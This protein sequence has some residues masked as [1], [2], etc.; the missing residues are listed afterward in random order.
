[1]YVMVSKFWVWSRLKSRVVKEKYYTW[2]Y[3]KSIKGIQASIDSILE[4][5][6]GTQPIFIFA[7]G[8]SWNRQLFQR[9]QQLALALAK[10]GA[11]VFYLDPLDS[12]QAP[13]FTQIDHQLFRVTGPAKLIEQVPKPFVYLLPWS[14][15][16]QARF[17]SP[18]II[19]DIV[20][21]L[22]AFKVNRHF[23]Y[24]QHEKRLKVADLVLVTA[25]RLYD[26][27]YPMR[28]DVILCPNG[29][30]YEHFHITGKTIPEDMKPIVD[31]NKPIIGYY[32]ALAEW[33]DYELYKSL[34]V[35]RPDLYFVLIGPDLDNSLGFSGLLSLSNVKWL[36]V[37]DYSELPACLQTFDIAT[38]PFMVNEI[39]NATSPIKMFEYMAG[40]KPIVATPINECLQTE[41]V[42]LAKTVEDFSQQIDLALALKVDKS[43]L[44]TI[45]KVSLENTWEF[46][47]K[48]I[49]DSI[50]QL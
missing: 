47:A 2:K 49:I 31:Q 4:K 33:F 41:G 48:Q 29:V 30:N 6:E 12:G 19:Y 44:A 32:G 9:P 25:R 36:G 28:N 35:A 37:K 46:R 23:L 13:K 3:W 1:M 22:K 21:D 34:A 14:Y 45:R 16:P 8:L 20:D 18:R 40:D 24:H 11:L 15:T 7:P 10:L 38:I 42:L 39:T 5:Q 26:Q 43:Y 17:K 27:Y 50:N